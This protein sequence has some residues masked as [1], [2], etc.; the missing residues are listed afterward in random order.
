MLGN[1]I[2]ICDKLGEYTD[3]HFIELE[4][5]LLLL[6]S[7]LGKHDCYNNLVI[8]V[9]IPRHLDR[10]FGT[11]GEHEDIIEIFF[12]AACRGGNLKLV[13]YLNTEKKYIPS[14]LYEAAIGGNHQITDFLANQN[15]EGEYLVGLCAGGHADL[16]RSNLE[17]LTEEELVVFAEELETHMR[18]VYANHN[19]IVDIIGI[20]E[21]FVQNFRDKQNA[22]IS[23]RLGAIE[24]DNLTAF[25]FV[26]D[27]IV[28]PDL[29]HLMNADKDMVLRSIIEHNAVNIA[30]YLVRE[31][32]YVAWHQ[33]R[34]ADLVEYVCKPGCFELFEAIYPLIDNETHPRDRNDRNL[35]LK[36]LLTE[37]C[38][39]LRIHGADLRRR[40]SR[41]S[42][43]KLEN[44]ILV[45]I[46][47]LKCLSFIQMCLINMVRVT[48]FTQ[49]F[50]VKSVTTDSWTQTDFM[51]K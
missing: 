46:P 6:F 7:E 18:D 20:I 44:S 3:E 47:L 15:V 13:E 29:S 48:L 43:L 14:S 19:N 11:R 16:L 30:N 35:I 31:K 42:W 49:Q 23:G 38:R 37:T 4:Y 22:M 33:Y 34:D 27:N 32:I 40:S 9:L 36:A 17:D 8:N 24:E 39:F 50:W 1:N 2:D 26:H 10:D 25:V 12:L 41:N 21:P 51:W 45:N 28:I 5:D